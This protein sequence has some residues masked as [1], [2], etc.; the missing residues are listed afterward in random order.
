M[1]PSHAALSTV[2]QDGVALWTCVIG[3]SILEAEAESSLLSCS[4]PK[5]NQESWVYDFPMYVAHL[6]NFFW[7]STS[8]QFD[9]AWDW[10]YGRDICASVLRPSNLHLSAVS[11]PWSLSMVNPTRSWLKHR[12][13]RGRRDY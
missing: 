13:S 7:E 5:V 1:R 8:A 11:A 9:A 3:I 2:T 4:K 10:M 6:A 12:Q